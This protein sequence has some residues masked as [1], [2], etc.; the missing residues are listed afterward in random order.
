VNGSKLR[1]GEGFVVVMIFVVIV[2]GN[3]E[4]GD[5]EEQRA[6]DALP[7]KRSHKNP[8]EKMWSDSSQEVEKGSTMSRGSQI[9][10]A[11]VPGGDCLERFFLSGEFP[12]SEFIP[13]LGMG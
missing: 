6:S 5:A 12:F 3:S 10:N 4:D 7:S 2:V 13:V 11:A 8:S 9:S 1:F